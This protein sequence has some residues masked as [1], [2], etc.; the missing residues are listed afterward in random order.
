[1]RAVGDEAAHRDRAAMT[2]RGDEHHLGDA[3]VADIAEV[4][5]LTNRQPDR[6]DPSLKLRIGIKAI[7]VFISRDANVRRLH[8]DAR[9]T[10]IDQRNWHAVH[11]IHHVTRRK[12]RAA[13]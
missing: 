8:H 10:V 3:L 12:Q 9:H 2:R 7:A 11:N 1:M 4:H 6:F 5:P 13:A